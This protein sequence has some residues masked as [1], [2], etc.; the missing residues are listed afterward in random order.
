MARYTIDGLLADITRLQQELNQSKSSAESQKYSHL[1]EIAAL[2]EVHAAALTKFEKEK[3]SSESLK[4]SYYNQYQD[5][6]KELD[7]IH[8]LLDALPDVPSREKEGQYGNTKR[9]L[10]TRLAAFLALRKGA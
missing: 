2:K 7:T 1:S 8:D 10:V 5:A 3:A 6:N 9:P 4:T